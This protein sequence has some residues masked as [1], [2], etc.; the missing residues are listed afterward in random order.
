MARTSWPRARSRSARASTGGTLPPPA[1]VTKRMRPTTG[2]YRPPGDRG[3]LTSMDPAEIYSTSRARLARPRRPSSTPISRPPPSRPTPPWTVVDGY[4]HLAGVCCDVL[5]GN[6]PQGGPAGRRRVD[7]RAAGRPGGLVAGPGVRA[8]DRARAGARRARR[9]AGAAMGFVALDA[10]THEQD[11]RDASGAGAL[12][13]DPLL[14]GLIEL[15]VGNMERFYAGQGGPPLRLVLDGEEHRTGDGEPTA[16]LVT[17]AYDLMRMVFGRR[18]QAQI[19]AADWSGDGAEAA[20]AAITLFPAQP[21][22]L[23]D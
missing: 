17:T 22:D 15:T 5:D 20:R 23:S 11:I 1:Q 6:M 14:P 21:Q 7:G 13:D 2:T 9:A 16:T 19:A 4:R 10:W 8:V 12:H 18:S 3:R